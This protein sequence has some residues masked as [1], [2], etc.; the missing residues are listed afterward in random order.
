MEREGERRRVEG[1]G[2]IRGEW[3][4]MRVERGGEETEADYCNLTQRSYQD[5]SLLQ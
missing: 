3:R 2:E 5:P 4:E 1:E